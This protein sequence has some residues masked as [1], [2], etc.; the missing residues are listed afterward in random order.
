MPKHITMEE[1]SRVIRLVAVI[2]GVMMVFN[3]FFLIK[4]SEISDAITYNNMER[5]SFF[6]N[7]HYECEYTKKEITK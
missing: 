4:I 6:L 7:E 2:A 3:L 5:L 1:T